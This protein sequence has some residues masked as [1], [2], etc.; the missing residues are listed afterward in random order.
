MYII[1]IIFIII[2][3][4]YYLEYK[5]WIF[6]VPLC[7]QS[8]LCSFLRLSVRSLM[9]TTF[10]SSALTIPTYKGIILHK[11]SQLLPCVWAHNS[12]TPKSMNFF[13]F[14]GVGWDWVP[15]VLRQLFGPGWCMMME[16]LGGQSDVLG[17]NLPQCHFIH[18][19]SHDLTWDRTPARGGENP[20]T[21]RVSLWYGF[22]E[23][24]VYC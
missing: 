10:P 18:H 20:A 21:F 9:L 13:K 12:V 24:L 16:S 3:L 1:I 23:K 14:L 19:K 5:T 22:R 4:H 11:G 2:I 6:A 8:L 15:L 17:G 7:T